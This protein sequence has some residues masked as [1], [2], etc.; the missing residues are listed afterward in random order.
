MAA[1]SWLFPPIKKQIHIPYFEFGPSV[2]AFF[3]RIWQK[4]HWA[5]FKTQ[6]FRNWQFLLPTLR[7]PSVGA[8][9]YQVKSPP[10][11]DHLSGEV[12]PHI[13][14]PVDSRSWV[15]SFSL[16]QG[17]RRESEAICVLQTSPSTNKYQLVTP[18]SV[19]W[20]TRIIQSSL[21]WI[22]DP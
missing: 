15:Q 3:N 12:T 7:M 19:M 14:T 2:N 9:R 6:A 1:H 16:Y 11:W 18:V 5:S 13:D 22:P 4:W 21:V 17:T 10:T 8:L 20:S